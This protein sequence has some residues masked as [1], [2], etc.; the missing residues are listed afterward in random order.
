M[1]VSIIG[2]IAGRYDELMDLLKKLPPGPIVCVG[3]LMDRGPDSRGVINWAIENEARVTCI[4]GNHEDLMINSCENPPEEIRMCGS[5]AAEIWLWNGGVS[6]LESYGD[7]GEMT[8]AEASRLIPKSH[9]EWIKARPRFVEFD[10]LI[11]SHAPIGYDVDDLRTIQHS[12]DFI[13]NRS[14]PAR[15]SKFQVFGHNARLQWYGETP[16]TARALCIDNSSNRELCALIWPSREI[17]REKYK[18]ART[19]TSANREEMK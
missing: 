3:D 10:D 2:D 18:A 19:P 17:V 5:H 11:I 14:S 16:A 12:T 4:Y 8:F 15:R 6:T 1:N 9:L 13:W 7:T